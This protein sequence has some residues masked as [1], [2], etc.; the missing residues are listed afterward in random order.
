MRTNCIV[1]ARKDGR[2]EMK[3]ILVLLLGIASGYF[4][5]FEDGWWAAGYKHGGAWDQQAALRMLQYEYAKEL[6]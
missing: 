4:F 6:P 3:L 2:D 1:A 5:G